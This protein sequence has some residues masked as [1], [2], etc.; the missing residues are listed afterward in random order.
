MPGKI[1]GILSNLEFAPSG[2]GLPMQRIKR[3]AFEFIE[4]IKVIG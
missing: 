3:S 1:Y 2:A 4:W